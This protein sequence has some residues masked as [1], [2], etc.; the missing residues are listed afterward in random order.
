MKNRSLKLGGL[1]WVM[2][3]TYSA[4]GFAATPTSGAY[5]TDTTDQYVEDQASQVLNQAN[6]VLCYMGA[7]N[8]SASAIVNSGAYV[9]LID[10][11]KC[12]SNSGGGKS[13]GAGASY[14][15]AIVNSTQTTGT[16]LVAKVWIEDPYSNINAKASATKSPSATLPYGA[17]SV[18]WCGTSAA[19]AA[20]TCNVEKGYITAGSTGLSYFASRSGTVRN[21]ATGT[22]VDALTLNAVNADSGSGS[23]NQ[24]VT[25]TGFSSNLTITFAYNAT[26]FLRTDDAGVTKRCF[27]RSLANA[28]KSAWS[29]GLYDS[30]GA[31]V[32]RNSG[33]PIEYTDATSGAVLNGYIGYWGLWT[34]SAT[35][36]ANGTTLTKI[37]Y[38]STG[39]PTKTNYTLLQSGGKLLKHTMA[40]K[41]LAAVN[42]QHFWFWANTNVPT[43]GTAVMTA[44]SSYELYWDNTAAQFMVYG[45]QNATTNNMEPLATPVAIANADMVAAASW[46]LYAWTNAGQWSIS[47]ASM[48]A[49]ATTT[50]ATPVLMVS[51]DIVYPDQYA[52]IGSLKCISDCPTPT[53]ALGTPA[54]ANAGFG[55]PWSATPNVLTAS[56]VSYTLNAT[57]GNLTNGA[58]AAVVNLTSTSQWSSAFNTQGSGKLIDATTFA[59]IV[60]AV[61][62]QY[63]VADLGA[64]TTYY[65]W[66]SSTNSWDQLSMLMSGTTPVKFDPPLAVEFVVPAN[67]A[68]TS[69]PYGNYAGTTVQLNYNGF[70][71]LQGIPSTC[72]DISTNAPCVFPATN[73]TF[74]NWKP[75]FL[76]PFDGAGVANPVGKVTFTPAGGTLTTYY[77]K[78]LNEEVRLSMVGSTC[79]AP[80]L[81]LPAAAPS[82]PQA[83]GWTDP[84]LGTAPT[85]ANTAPRVIDG[86]V[87]Y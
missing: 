54:F 81:T 74:Y 52:A 77:V 41:T 2:C 48:A 72:V 33:F 27:D 19:A 5:V 66:R 70:G 24:A 60:P 42:K 83:G 18:N 17:F 71:D 84:A 59:A 50:S 61:A 67:T 56:V 44:G 57:T 22:Q 34:Q 87:M 23:M 16:P 82:L 12:D 25:A 29:Y 26:H 65:T 73:T 32:N 14:Q 4:T 43:T 62:G 69:K 1:V 68:G 63:N 21:G 13:T 40:N 75:N 46:G 76:I 51:E 53:A 28:D 6:S 9:A 39:A 36:P 37:V 58:A 20:G 38:N 78:P 85:P 45:K 35:P 86:V 47:S 30:T 31:R 55:T 64:V 11:K 15:K 10:Q 80:G 3:A 8:P 7:M 49:L 79:P